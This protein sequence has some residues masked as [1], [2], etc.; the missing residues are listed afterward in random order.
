[1]LR[2]EVKHTRRPLTPKERER[3]AEARRLITTEEPEI[4]RKVGEYKRQ[5]TEKH[6]APRDDG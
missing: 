6:Q 4:R 5:H 3:V 1:M 2:R